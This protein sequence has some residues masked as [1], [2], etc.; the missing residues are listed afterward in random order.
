MH[1]SIEIPVTALSAIAGR[2]VTTATRQI[3]NTMNAAEPKSRTPRLKRFSRYSYADVMPRR[4]KNG[5]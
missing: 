1:A 2:S 3:I 5:R 4:Q